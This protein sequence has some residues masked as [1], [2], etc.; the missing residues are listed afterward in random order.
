MYH[1]LTPNSYIK[2]LRFY[3]VLNSF[4]CIKL[5]P[6]KTVERDSFVAVVIYGHFVLLFCS[7]CM[8]E[9][10]VTYIKHGSPRDVSTQCFGE[11]H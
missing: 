5:F 8:L 11:N 10:Y 1:T 4:D 6:L 7:C 3:P 9:T 2:I